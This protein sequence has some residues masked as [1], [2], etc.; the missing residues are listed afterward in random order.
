MPMDLV[1]PST[2]KPSV[3]AVLESMKALSLPDLDRVSLLNRVDTKFLLPV[4]KI[5]RLLERLAIHYHVLEIEDKRI[6]EYET[7]YFDT[8]DWQFYDAHHRGKPHRFKVRCRSYVASDLHFFEVKAKVAGLRTDKVRLRR[9]NRELVLSSIETDLLKNKF[10]IHT[11]LFFKLWTNFD[12]ITLAS[13]SHGERLT[14]DLNLS[15]ERF[16]QRASLAQVGIIELKQGR[17]DLMSPARKALREVQAAPMGFSK[18]A[19]GASQLEPS[20]KRNA[21]KPI[22]LKLNKL[23]YA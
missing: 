6:F 15:F 20:L 10:G 19:V 7:A 12:R 17:A 13:F 2:Y 18:Y 3:L 8:E 21:F 1:L 22:F 23:S 9:N 4:T 11:P 5:P 14:I 16:H